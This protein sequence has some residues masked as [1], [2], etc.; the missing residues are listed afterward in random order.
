MKTISFTVPGFSI[1]LPAFLFCAFSL[2]ASASPAAKFKTPALKARPVYDGVPQTAQQAAAKPEGSTYTENNPVTRAAI[3]AGVLASARRIDQVITVMT[4][5]KPSGAYLFIPQ[6]EPDQNIF[7]ASLE[8]QTPAATPIY[9]SVSF[10]PLTSG[11][12]GTLYDTVEYDPNSCAFIAQNASKDLKYAGVLRKD[13]VMLDGGPVR[14]FLM[15]AG[16]GCIVIKKEV[17]R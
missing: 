16:T 15:P 11:E 12:T 2:P 1:L 10:A 3:N 4:A 7:S 17:V 6:A 8:I 13:I 5:D 9:T 14:I